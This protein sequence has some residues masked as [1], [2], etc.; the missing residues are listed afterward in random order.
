MARARLLKP[1]FFTN[2]EL[3]ELPMAARLLFAGL[4]T[5]AD[6]EGRLDDRPKRI[7]AEVFPYDRV[8]VEWMLDKLEEVGFIQRYEIGQGAFIQIVNFEKH[9]HPHP[10]EPASVIP[11]PAD[12]MTRPDNVMASQAVAK[13]EAV[14]EANTEAEAVTRPRFDTEW[15]RHCEIL[16]GKHPGGASQVAAAQLERDFGYEACMQAARDTEWQKHPNYLRPILEERRDKSSNRG[17]ATAADTNGLA[18]GIHGLDG[19]EP[20]IAERRRRRTS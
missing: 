7:K 10:H 12:V 15:V 17:A 2:E 5:L 20:S 9:Q 13:A 19:P 6:R 1:G 4:W 8:N 3:C 16:R 14:A 11:A 18:G